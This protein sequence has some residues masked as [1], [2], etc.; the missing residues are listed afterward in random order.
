MIQETIVPPKTGVLLYLKVALLSLLVLF[1]YLPELRSMMTAWS[2]SP[3]YSHGYL[4]PLISGYIIWRKVGVLRD[5]PAKPDFRGFFI[6][7]A[8]VAL[9]IIGQVG[10]EHFTMRF[11]LIVTI[12]GLVYFLLGN[13]IVKTLLF[14]LGYLTFMIPVPY[15]ILKSLA[16]GLK[17]FNAKATYAILTLAGMSLVREGTTL[18]LPTCTL[19]VA[20]FCTGI[21]SLIAISAIT[22][23][24]AYLTQKS[25]LSKAILI[26]LAIPFAILGNLGRLVV[27]VG[28]AYFYGEKALGSIV[29]QFQGTVSFLFTIS[30]VFLVGRLLQKLDLKTKSVVSS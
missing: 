30:F 7:L 11:S 10:Y 12:V 28:L 8:G 24:Y 2:E 14:P 6:V 4:I 18:E 13:K 19:L 25:L 26:I 15:S 3:E 9:L 5:M 27:T 17:L 21:L 22:V 23:L 1:L 16:V 29:H 20:D